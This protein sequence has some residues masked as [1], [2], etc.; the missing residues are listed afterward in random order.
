MAHLHIDLFIG[1]AEVNT[2]LDPLFA[3]IEKPHSRAWWQRK[4]PVRIWLSGALA[5]PFML[6]PMA[7]LKSWRELTLWAESCAAEAVG[8]S[9][10]CQVQ[11]EAWPENHPTLAV[12]MERGLLESIEAQASLHNLHVQCIR[13]GWAEVANELWQQQP[14]LRLIGVEDADAITLLG[15][16]NQQLNRAHSYWPKPA[17]DQIDPLLSR[18]ALVM[19][20]TAKETHRTKFLPLERG[21]ARMG[22]KN[23]KHHATHQ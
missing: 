6:E 21:K 18:M 2:G 23:A 20:A 13:P 17:E 14:E 1:Q 16:H 7:G 4:T 8:M 11:V 12:A 19:G 9:A 22:V 5:R 10:P 15:S 3:S